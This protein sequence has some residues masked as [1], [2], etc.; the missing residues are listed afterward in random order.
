[1]T[2]TQAPF[3]TDKGDGHLYHSSEL[4]SV[5]D[6]YPLSIQAVP[7]KALTLSEFVDSWTDILVGY[8]YESISPFAGMHV[9]NAS[10]PMGRYYSWSTFHSVTI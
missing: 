5:T 10:Q 6:R 1:M 8:A 4:S 9:Y 2:F 7:V 3:I